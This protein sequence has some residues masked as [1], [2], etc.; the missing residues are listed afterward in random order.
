MAEAAADIRRLV[1]GLRPPMLDDIGLVE[2]LRHLR[3]VPHDPTRRVRPAGGAHPGLDQMARGLNNDAIADVLGY[4][5]K[6][7]RNYVSI[8]F[9]KL[10]VADRAQAIILARDRGLT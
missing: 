1:D 5:P 6:T 2:A 8:I 3:F 10:H 7:I 4:S 9:A